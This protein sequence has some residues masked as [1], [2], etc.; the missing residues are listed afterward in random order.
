MVCQGRLYRLGRP[1][2]DG[3]GKCRAPDRD[4]G[5]T[6]INPAR[7]SA[8]PDE[9]RSPGSRN[10]V[11]QSGARR[12]LECGCERPIFLAAGTGERGDPVE[13]ILRLITVALFELPQAVIL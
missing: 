7:L 13:V 12:L 11:N 2:R 1:C 6:Q 5:S 8:A 4:K 3:R 10:S 9:S